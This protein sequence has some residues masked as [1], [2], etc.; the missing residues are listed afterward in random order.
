MIQVIYPPPIPLVT[1]SNCF[2]EKT[3]SKIGKKMTS[4]YNSVQLVSAIILL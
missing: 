4:K 2:T 3:F 1:N